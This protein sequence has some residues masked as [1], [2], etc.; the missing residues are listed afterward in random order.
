MSLITENNRQYYEGSQGFEAD[1]NLTTFVT[2]F[3]TDLKFYAASRSDLDYNLNNFKLY[4]SETLLPGSWEEILSG[5]TI[6]GN[7][8]KFDTPPLGSVVVQLKRLDGGVYGNDIIDKAVG[9]A[10]EENYGSYS[11]TKLDDIINNFIV[12]YVG[13]GKLIPSVKPSDVMFHAKRAMQE[14]SYDTLRSVNSV[15][16]TVPYSLSLVIPQDYVNYISISWIDND[17]I[18]HPI[19]KTNRTVNPTSAPL[20]ESE[21]TPMVDE[22]S[23]KIET[24]SITESRY[25]KGG[26]NVGASID[27]ADRS[28]WDDFYGTGRYGMDP[29]NA[30]I[31][32]NFTINERENKFSFSSDL[33]DK[34]IVIEYI[35]DGLS[36]NGETKVHKFAEG[37]M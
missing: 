1:G 30:N 17:G 18:K 32:G 19:S 29:Q 5:Y 23:Q 4:L 31:N 9:T 25:V 14:L 27:Y 12:S 6:I 20:Q 28:V 3:N 26:S 22:F 37:A 15:E 34:I 24:D 16:L 2:T 7:T 11:Y 13:V 35:S 8:V 33:V 21:G 10:V 36:V